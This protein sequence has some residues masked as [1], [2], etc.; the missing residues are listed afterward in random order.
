MLNQAIEEH[1][2]QLFKQYRFGN[3]LSVFDKYFGERKETKK[4]VI[5]MIAKIMS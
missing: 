1:L 2:A 5:L 4:I 3:Y